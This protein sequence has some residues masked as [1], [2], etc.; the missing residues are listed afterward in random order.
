MSLGGRECC[1][2]ACVEASEVFG[3]AAK[4]DVVESDDAASSS[5]CTITGSV[6]IGVAFTELTN[7]VAQNC[8]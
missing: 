6:V 4:V 5:P 7:G 1:C 3:L 2:S 8:T